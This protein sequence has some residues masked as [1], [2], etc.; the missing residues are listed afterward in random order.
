M[1][2]NI[3]KN[4]IKK[5][6]ASEVIANIFDINKTTEQQYDKIPNDSFPIKKSRVSSE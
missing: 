2:M 1:F 5:W 4:G 6:F 3:P